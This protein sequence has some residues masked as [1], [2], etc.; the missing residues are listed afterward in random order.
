MTSPELCL[1]FLILCLVFF[2]A[3]TAVGCLMTANQRLIRTSYKHTYI[4]S[5]QF[6]SL[7]FPFSS[8]YISYMVHI[9][10]YILHCYNFLSWLHISWSYIPEYEAS[11]RRGILHNFFHI[12]GVFKFDVS[13]LQGLGWIF[14]GW[15]WK[16]CSSCYVVGD[17]SLSMLPMLQWMHMVSVFWFLLWRGLR[18][19][20]V[21]GSEFEK[22]EGR[23]M[24]FKGW[25]Y[26]K[27]D[28]VW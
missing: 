15:P 26:F 12:N 17:C 8:L 19:C 16:S 24:V 13:S 11:I 9:C 2:E 28:S 21:C 1:D 14:E 25:I 22:F 23:S 10:F 4:S 18:I 27:C 6:T 5:A 20:S 3:C 7:L